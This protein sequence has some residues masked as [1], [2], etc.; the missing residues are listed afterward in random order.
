MIFVIEGPDGTGKSTLAQAIAKATNGEPI[1]CSFNKHWNMKEY[2]HA[3]LNH[4]RDLDA[5]GIT[6]IF[7]RF[8]ASERVYGDVF[9]TGESYDTDSL[10]YYI[11]E[12]YQ[13]KWIYCRNDNAIENHKKHMGERYEMYDDMT[14]IAKGF[15]KYVK[16]HKDLGWYV[17]DYDKVDTATFIKQLLKGGE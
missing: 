7:D 1:H 14:E 3:K 15:E 9:R 17:F 11:N 16:Q 12:V 2:H 10:V 13:I 5:K 8:A 4:A 6:P